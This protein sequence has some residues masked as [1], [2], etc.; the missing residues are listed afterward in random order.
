MASTSG[1]NITRRGGS[2]LQKIAQK[3]EQLK[4]L[5]RMKKIERISVHL[6]C[7]VR[8]LFISF[9]PLITLSLPAQQLLMSILALFSY[10]GEYSIE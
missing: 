9:N 10:T 4:Q 7:Q 8:R 5:P 3:K 2:T 1:K 6:S